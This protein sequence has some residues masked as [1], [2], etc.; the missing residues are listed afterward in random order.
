MKNKFLSIAALALFT[1]S[2]AACGNCQRCD[3][4]NLTRIPNRGTKFCEKDYNSTAEYEAAIADQ[5]S[6]GC[7]C[8]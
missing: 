6:S 4:L 3:C 1:F 2:I 7:V 8:N 5:D